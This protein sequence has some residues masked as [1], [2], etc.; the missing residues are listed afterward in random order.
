M[1]RRAIIIGMLVAGVGGVAVSQWIGGGEGILT[2]DGDRVGPFSDLGAWIPQDG[3][4]STLAMAQNCCTH[5]AAQVAI[6]KQINLLPEDVN[7][8]GVVSFDDITMILSAWG[9]T[10]E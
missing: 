3:V 8:D 4:Y 5:L 9:Q 6:N 1:K 10:S 2:T 7:R